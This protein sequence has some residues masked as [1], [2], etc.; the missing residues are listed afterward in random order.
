VWL[1]AITAGG[2]RHTQRVPARKSGAAV[3]ERYAKAYAS[4]W[5]R[6]ADE[7]E[8][9]PPSASSS[10]SPPGVAAPSADMTVGAW[11]ERW[12]AGLTHWTTS[13]DRSAVRIHVATD[14]LAALRLRDV[15]LRDAVAFVERLRA[16]PAARG[17]SLL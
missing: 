17:R 3:D 4:E 2:K 12:A 7:G 9:S 11:A 16:K 1:A 10:G 6:R 8:W 13:D 5:Q 15:T 14:P